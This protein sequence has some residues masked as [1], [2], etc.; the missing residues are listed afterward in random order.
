MG[1]WAVV[2]AVFSGVR[3]ERTLSPHARAA[4]WRSSRE[5]AEMHWRTCS[6][7]PR[8]FAR[9]AIHRAN[10]LKMEL[11]CTGAQDMKPLGVVLCARQDAG[12]RKSSSLLGLRSVR[13]DERRGG[14]GVGSAHRR[15][16]WSE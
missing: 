10:V 4:A 3:V 7:Q 1:A 13:T 8:G 14:T 16:W 12:P 15:G 5:D 9:Y 2:I 6:R 11:Q